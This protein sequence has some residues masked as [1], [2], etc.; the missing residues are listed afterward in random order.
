MGEELILEEIGSKFAPIIQ[1]YKCNINVF[2]K[3][4]IYLLFTSQGQR[5]T[6]TEAFNNMYFQKTLQN[7]NTEQTA[8]YNCRIRET[9]QNAI[10]YGGMVYGCYL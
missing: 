8:P 9:L 2:G 1:L 3:Q 6:F 7:L 4:K 10:C 5:A